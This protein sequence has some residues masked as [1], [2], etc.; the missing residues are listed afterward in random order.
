MKLFSKNNILYIGTNEV[1][2]LNGSF[3]KVI[4]FSEKRAIDYKKVVSL[5]EKTPT[6]IFI[7]SFFAFAEHRSISAG[8]GKKEIKKSI[9]ERLA[10]PDVVCA[11]YNHL[12]KKGKGGTHTNDV[13][14]TIIKADDS[15]QHIKKILSLLANTNADLTSLYSFDQAINS[16][17]MSYSIFNHSININVVLLDNSAM[18]MASN[19]THFMFGRLIKKRDGEEL[20]TTTSSMLAMTLKYISTT[21][22]FLTN[23]QK[24]TIMSSGDVDINAIRGSDPI[25]GDIKITTKKLSLPKITQVSDIKGITTELQLLKLAVS[26]LKYV[27]KLNNNRISIQTSAFLAI[28]ILKRMAF[29]SILITIVYCFYRM[30]DINKLSV[31][32]KQIETKFDNISAEANTQQKKIKTLTGKGYYFIA[33]EL[34]NGIYDNSHVDTMK[35]IADIFKKH[36]DLTYVEG[37]KLSCENCA[38][39]DRKNTLTIDFAF[40]NVNS[41]ARYAVD[42]LSAIETEIL[43]LLN[44][45]YKNVNISYSQLTKN[46]RALATKDVRDT[47][48]IT[49]SE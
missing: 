39:K 13:V 25:F 27:N 10:K 29:V 43:T 20:I 44:K 17:S 34:K 24:I 19:T 7:N 14:M 49:F 28:V 33:R 18:I 16:L 8:L 5:V 1:C 46:K 21:Y 12:F 36:R 3:S 11:T 2:L 47:M 41:S 6:T 37:Y 42:K 48:I 38:Q 35:K 4:Y 31:Y 32:E 9:D 40:Y 23:E 45:D 30:L 22:S 15:E 26:S